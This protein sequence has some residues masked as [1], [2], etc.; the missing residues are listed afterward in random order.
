MINAAIED[1]LDCIE[2]FDESQNGD[3]DDDDDDE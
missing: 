3:D 1:L 2:E